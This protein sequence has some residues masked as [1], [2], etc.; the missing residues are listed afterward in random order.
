MDRDQ[1]IDDLS[2]AIS[3]LEDAIDALKELG[4][5]SVSDAECLADM[6]RVYAKER[7]ALEDDRA[8]EYRR[9]RQADEDDYWKSR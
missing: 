2:Y 7:S 6:I 9:D 3:C 1:R 5:D 4:E 8:E